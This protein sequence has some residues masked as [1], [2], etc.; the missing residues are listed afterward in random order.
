MKRFNMRIGDLEVRTCNKSLIGSGQH[1]TAEIIRWH[2]GKDTCHTLA[3][4]VKD[5]DGFY[6][7][8]VGSRPLKDD[9]CDPDT[10]WRLTKAGQDYLDYCGDIHDDE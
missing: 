8:Y 5:D 10:W 7:K 9:R 6:L 4:W 1:T 3:Y 2:E